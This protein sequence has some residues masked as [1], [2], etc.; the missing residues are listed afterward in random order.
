[1]EKFRDKVDI[2]LGDFNEKGVINTDMAVHKL[3]ASQFMT[4]E[5]LKEY[6]HGPVT[7]TVAPKFFD[8]DKAVRVYTTKEDIN[9]EEQKKE[10]MMEEAM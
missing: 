8:L 7:T 6:P 10:A 4:K 5:E 1:M 3:D 2:C 9:Q